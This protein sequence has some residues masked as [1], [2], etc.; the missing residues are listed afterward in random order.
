MFRKMKLRPP[1][2][3]FMKTY[4]FFVAYLKRLNGRVDTVI[5]ETLIDFYLV[6]VLAFLLFYFE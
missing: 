2:K 5:Y 4:V 3:T 1:R 6:S